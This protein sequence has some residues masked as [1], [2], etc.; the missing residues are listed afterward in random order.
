MTSREC[1]EAV[2]PREISEPRPTLLT[3]R[4]VSIVVHADVMTRGTAA[5]MDVKL[6]ATIWTAM[7]M[8]AG[9]MTFLGPTRVMFVIVENFIPEIVD[10]YF[11]EFVSGAVSIAEI[12]NAI[13]D[14]V[15]VDAGDIVSLFPSEHGAISHDFFIKVEFAKVVCFDDAITVFNECPLDR[16]VYTNRCGLWIVVGIFEFF[17]FVV[18]FEIMIFELRDFRFGNLDFFVADQSDAMIEPVVEA[19]TE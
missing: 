10:V 11:P 8:H 1:N 14:D 13:F 3:V 9:S 6:V 16:K 7:I 19:G 2:A 17:P 12:D 4:P 15:P 18:M 5:F